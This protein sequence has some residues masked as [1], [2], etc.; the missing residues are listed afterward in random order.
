MALFRLTSENTALTVVDAQSKL[1]DVMR[2]G[3]AIVENIVRLLHLA[4]LFD[5]PVI[6]TEQH[7]K[8]LGPTVPEIAEQ[9][10]GRSDRSGEEPAWPEP[11][12]KMTFSCC[13]AEGFTDRLEATGAKTVVLT[14]IETHVCILQTCL[15]LLEDGYAV[16]VPQ[17]AVDSRTEENC[18]VG[19]E[20]M[21]DAGAVITSTETAIFQVL[22]QAGTDQFKLIHRIVK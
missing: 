21:R 6:A 12:S 7:R 10:T 1:L 13:A 4:R 5:L 14:G 9:L 11:I 18:Q 16:H 2:R 22:R 19:I 8:M 17:D 20:L 15:D 3:P